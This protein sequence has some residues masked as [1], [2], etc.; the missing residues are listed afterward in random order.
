MDLGLL[1]DH[2]SWPYDHDPRGNMIT[3]CGQRAAS[4]VTGAPPHTVISCHGHRGARGRR[5][6]ARRD[7]VITV[8]RQIMIGVENSGVV[9]LEQRDGDGGDDDGEAEQD[10]ELG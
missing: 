3:V 6:A 2:Q 7:T 4:H 10:A 9:P 5:V 8:M 1:V